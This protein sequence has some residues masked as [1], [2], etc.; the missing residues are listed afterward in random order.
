[1]RP[2]LSW[3]R[4]PTIAMIALVGLGAAQVPSPTSPALVLRGGT[5]ID[6]DLGVA[7]AATVLIQ[8]GRIVAV[9]PDARVPVPSGARVVDARGKFIMPGLWDAHVHLSWTTRSALPVLVANGVTSVR[10][11]G[12]RLPEL[13]AWRTRISV[14]ELVGP[15][16]FRAGP[17]LNG[18]R[19]N[20][21]QL[22]VGGPDEARGI[23]RAL[24][25][26]GVDF[27]KVHRR[28][29]SE[30]LLALLDEAQ[31]VGLAV[32]GH[33]PMTIPPEE[34]TALGFVSFE[35]TETLFEGT[36]AAAAAAAKEPLSTAVRRYRAEALGRLI[37]ALVAKHVRFTPTLVAYRSQID[38]GHP[39][40]LADLR[41]RYVAASQ[42]RVLDKMP[43][44][45]ADD[46]AELEVMFAELLA[47]VRT[48]NAGGVELLVGTDS[49]GPRL[50]G[51][52]VHDELALLVAA[53]LTPGQALAAA[54]SRPARLMGLADSGRVVEGQR[55]DLLMLDASPLVDIRNT[56][57]IRGVVLDGRWLD[58]A[59]LDSLLKE[60]EA[61][62]S[63]L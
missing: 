16:I 33:I 39:S 57:R 47:V 2:R 59:G 6:P 62:A 37:E 18:Q 54:T 13:D 32:A 61:L 8:A 40:A 26:A 44:P 43:R 29:P 27:L 51:F 34:A 1:M 20:Q 19:F 23:V 15:R 50:P 28:V 63:A 42:R 41:M 38:L 49:A 31:K 25:E 3:T 5:V 4:W 21:Y 35:H 17:I 12:G 45:S 60:A 22:V 24:K 48:M 36:V 53:G 55:A 10:D 9:G 56:T 30:S 14:G 7:T 52:P 58:R 11:M 46:M